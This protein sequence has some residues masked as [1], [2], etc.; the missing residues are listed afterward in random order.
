MLQPEQPKLKSG[1][2]EL[3]KTHRCISLARKVFFSTHT[4]ILRRQRIKSRGSSLVERSNARRLSKTAEDKS[5]R[6]ES[7]LRLLSRSL[8]QMDLQSIFFG[9]IFTGDKSGN[10]EMTRCEKRSS[11]VALAQNP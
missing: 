7:R 1:D 10:M 4:L 9:S 8:T 11:K 3:D 5:P 6:F 2:V